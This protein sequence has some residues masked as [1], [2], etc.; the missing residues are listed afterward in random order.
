Y[1]RTTDHGALGTQRH[2]LEHVLPRTNAAVHPDVDLRTYGLDYRRQHVDRRQ[3]AVELA[4]TMV[5]DNQR[6]GA[7]IRRHARIFR[8]EHTLEDNLAAPAILEPLDVGPAQL[9]IELFG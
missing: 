3:R 8:V 9:R 6:I 1:E 2:C 7:A 4:T 5:A